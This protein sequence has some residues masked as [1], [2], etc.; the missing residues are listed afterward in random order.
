MPY[1]VGVGFGSYG[2]GLLFVILSVTLIVVGIALLVRRP[3]PAI[4]P[5]PSPDPRTQAQR[6]LEERFARG[7]IDEAEYRGRLEVLVGA[8]AWADAPPPSVVAADRGG[9]TSEPLQ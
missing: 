9:E 8:Q 6:I 7:E 4:P 2:L 5:P 3:A 1:H